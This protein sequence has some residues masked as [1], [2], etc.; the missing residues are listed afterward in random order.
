M[1]RYNNE[2]T[3]KQTKAINNSYIYIYHVNVTQTVPDISP[4]MPMHQDP[5]L[6]Y[7]D[8]IAYTSPNRDAGCCCGWVG[9]GGGGGY[10]HGSATG[11]STLNVF[12]NVPECYLHQ[13]IIVQVI[14]HYAKPNLTLLMLETEYSVLFGPR[15]WSIPY[16]LMPWRLKSSGHQQACYW[17]NMNTYFIISETIQHVKRFKIVWSPSWDSCTDSIFGLKWP[18]GYTSFIKYSIS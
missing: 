1:C 11:D 3:T 5:L 10:H 18:H 6:V 8:V 9:G 16:L 13:K 14:S 4:L 7:M 12:R 17:Q 2:Q 15:V